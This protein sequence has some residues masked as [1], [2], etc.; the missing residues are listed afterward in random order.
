MTRELQIELDRHIARRRT[1][2]RRVFVAD[3]IRARSPRAAVT[4]PLAQHASSI[5]PGGDVRP[6]PESIA[7]TT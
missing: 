6:A 7:L 3:R 1:Q 2:V 4:D 5:L